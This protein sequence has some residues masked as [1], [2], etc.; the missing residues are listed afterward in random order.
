MGGKL[1]W[2]AIHNT[3]EQST[4]DQ[5]MNRIDLFAPVRWVIE[6]IISTEE[7]H[8]GDVKLALCSRTPVSKHMT[9]MLSTLMIY[10]NTR[11]NVMAG[12]KEKIPL[13]N[14]FQLVEFYDIPKNNHFEALHS[15]LGGKVDYSD[16]MFFDDNQKEIDRVAPL[17]VYVVHTPTGFN[18][19]S[20]FTTAMDH[21]QQNKGFND[22]EDVE[23]NHPQHPDE[24]DIFTQR[25]KEDIRRIHSNGENLEDHDPFLKSLVEEGIALKKM[26]YTAQSP[27]LSSSFSMSNESPHATQHRISLLGNAAIL[28]PAFELM[29]VLLALFPVAVMSAAL[30]HSKMLRRN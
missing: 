24:D 11:E 12:K 29:L 4:Q 20:I 10:N 18:D 30:F 7:Y 17:G 6:M 3:N 14:A 5:A 27:W 16:M 9:Q 21:W 23:E 15:K 13:F 19:I 26:Q 1:P 25:R 22:D 8:R 2:K 28:S